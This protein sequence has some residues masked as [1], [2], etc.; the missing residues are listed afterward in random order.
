[1]FIF[2]TLLYTAVIYA[3]TVTATTLIGFYEGRQLS[4][5]QPYLASPA[6]LILV[7]Y[8]LLIYSFLVFFLQI[9]HLLGEGVLWKFIRGKYHKPREEERIFMFLDM[10]SST[11]IAEHLGHVRFYTLLNE[12][13]HEISQPVIQTKAEI[14]QY[15]GDEVVLT[16]EMEDGLKNSNCLKIFFMFQEILHRNGEN[17]FKKFGVTPAF[18]AGLHFGKVVS[19]QIGDLKREIVYNGDVLNTTARIQNECNKYQR[20]CLVS[21]TLM[22]KLKQMNGFLWEKIDTVTLRGKESE[23]ELFSVSNPKPFAAL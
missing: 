13:F 4:E 14:Y 9:N 21:G 18:K 3:V 6:Q 11:T 22:N 10:K 19:A 23:V 16:W 1:M 2:K 8:T 5:L 15:V 7:V 12:L 17:Y 20:D